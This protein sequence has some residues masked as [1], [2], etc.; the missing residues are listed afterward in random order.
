MRLAESRGR[1]LLSVRSPFLQERPGSHLQTVPVRSDE[2]NKGLCRLVQSTYVEYVAPAMTEWTEVIQ[3]VK[4]L[5][6][7][8]TQTGNAPH[9]IHSVAILARHEERIAIAA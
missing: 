3:S 8:L 4:P 1:P 7:D 6:V 9:T 5:A 2:I